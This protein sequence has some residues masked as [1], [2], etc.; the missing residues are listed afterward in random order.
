MGGLKHVIVDLVVTT[1]VV[2]AALSGPAWARWV[3]VVYTPFLLILKIGVL[4]AAAPRP[5]LPGRKKTGAG[6][7]DVPVG[8]LHLLYGINFGVLLYDR[9][10]LKAGL[11]AAIWVLSTVAERRLRSTGKDEQ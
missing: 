3:V 7:R 9:W 1:V 4:L 5:P 10:F 8:F 11:W 2:I 6:S